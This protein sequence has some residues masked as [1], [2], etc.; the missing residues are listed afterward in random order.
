[1]FII[2]LLRK[3]KA[4]FPAFYTIAYNRLGFSFLCFLRLYLLISCNS[5]LFFAVIPCFAVRILLTPI[6]WVIQDKAAAVI[7]PA[8]DLTRDRVVVYA[9][10]VCTPFAAAAHYRAGHF[11]GQSGLCL[12]LHIF[13]DG[14]IHCGLGEIH[15]RLIQHPGHILKIFGGADFVD[16]VFDP[17][18]VE[19]RLYRFYA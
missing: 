4:I 2:F 1:M 6:P 11:W 16:D 5:G 8:I 13:P 3:F 12:E 14:I 10:K 18:C 19:L 7:M 17:L 15:Y 9:G